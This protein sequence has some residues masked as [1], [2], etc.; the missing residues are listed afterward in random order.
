[1]ASVLIIDDDNEMRATLRKI[2]EGAGHTVLDAQDGKQALRMYAGN[3]TDLVITDIYMPKMDGIEFVMRV[4]EA[5]PE[6]RIIALSGGG[7]LGKENALAAA[8]SLGAVGVLE[9]PFSI[10]ECLELVEKV[11]EEDS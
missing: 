8:S 3:P 4:C 11:L 6:A 7:Y 9:K 5:F 2:L 10:D 1:M